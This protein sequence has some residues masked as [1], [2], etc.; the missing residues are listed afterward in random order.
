MAIERFSFVANK[1]KETVCDTSGWTVVASIN[2]VASSSKPLLIQCFAGTG[3]QQSV[4][5]TSQMSQWVSAPGS[6]ASRGNRLSGKVGGSPE[7]G[8]FKNFLL[9]NQSSFSPEMASC[10]V[11]RTR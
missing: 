6:P 3:I 11:V 5:S 1:L 10:L 9:R 2:Q 7:A 4:T 8:H